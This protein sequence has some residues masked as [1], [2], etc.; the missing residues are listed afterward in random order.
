MPEITFHRRRCGNGDAECDRLDFGAAKHVYSP[1]IEGLEVQGEER[2]TTLFSIAGQSIIRSS[3]TLVSS[4]RVKKSDS[5]RRTSEGGEYRRRW[6]IEHNGVEMK[7]IKRFQEKY[8][9]KQ[10]EHLI[11]HRTRTR[12][13]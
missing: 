9:T 13:T 7:F 5:K 8:K 10:E 3:D 11:R 6:E 12:A 2:M 4:S 1:R